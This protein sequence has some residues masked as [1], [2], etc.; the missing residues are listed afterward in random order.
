MY[1][2][3]PCLYSNNVAWCKNKNVK[4]SLFGIGVR[5]CKIYPYMNKCNCEYFEMTPKPKMT[6]PKCGSGIVRPPIKIHLKL[7]VVADK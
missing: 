1:I 7:I 6:P 4:R 2:N 5:C 3:N